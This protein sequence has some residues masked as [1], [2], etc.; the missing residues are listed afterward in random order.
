[1]D[2]PANRSWPNLAGLSKDYLTDALKA[3]KDGARNNAMMAGIVKDL[4]DADADSVAAYF[5]GAS[6]K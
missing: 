4:S 6:C 3:Y 5:A 2:A 1:M